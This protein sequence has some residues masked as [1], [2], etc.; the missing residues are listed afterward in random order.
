VKIVA[1]GNELRLAAGRGLLEPSLAAFG[2]KYYMTIRAEDNRGYVTVSDD[3][4]KWSEKRPWCWDDGEPLM[5]SSTQQR[6]LVHS[7]GLF[8]VYTRK[9]PE[10]VNVVRWRSPL[11]VAEV[12]PRRQ[13][14]LRRSERIALPL[15]G[16]GINDPGNV[17]HLGNFHTNA[18]SA[19]TSII[20]VGEVIPKTFRGDTL[21]ARVRWSR[22][23]RGAAG[24]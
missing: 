14:L 9:A 12:D 13:C 18:V 21:V 3:G 2:G 16:D 20:T 23:N 19:D 15:A 6:W 24:L 17:A 7:G 8:L 10:N 11:Y 1:A 22:P 5:L 4:L